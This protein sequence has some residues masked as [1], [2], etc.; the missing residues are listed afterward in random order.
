MIIPKANGDHFKSIMKSI[1][2]KYYRLS[3]ADDILDLLEMKVRRLVRWLCVQYDN[4]SFIALAGSC[5][6]SQRSTVLL[7]LSRLLRIKSSL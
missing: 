3:R 6:F 5:L 7:P 2:I 4:N 1:M